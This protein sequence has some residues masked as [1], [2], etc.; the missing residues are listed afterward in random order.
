M[1]DNCYI[2]VCYFKE[3]RGGKRAKLI[4]VF[5]VFTLNSLVGHSHLLSSGMPAHGGL[6][7]LV[8]IP[9]TSLEAHCGPDCPWG[10][11]SISWTLN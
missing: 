7:S 2:S 3:A 9:Q 8:C 6:G 4:F 11:G 5:D 1:K 10:W